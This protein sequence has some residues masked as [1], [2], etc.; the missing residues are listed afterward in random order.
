MRRNMSNKVHNS[1]NSHW[2]QRNLV[3]VGRLHE[4]PLFGNYSVFPGNPV[5]SFKR[6]L[7]YSLTLIK[8]KN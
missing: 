6:V 2:I 8:A 3:K 5:P 7:S 1:L 4:G